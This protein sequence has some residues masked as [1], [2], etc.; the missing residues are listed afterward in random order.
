MEDNKEPEVLVVPVKRKYNRKETA[1]E[2]E[3]ETETNETSTGA[4][5]YLDEIKKLQGE[6]NLANNKVVELTKIVESMKGQYGQLEQALN[7][8]RIKNQA[9]KEFML[10]AAKHL[11]ISMTMAAK[12]GV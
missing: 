1:V 8:E 6:L 9:T 3:P 11:Y 7:T 12:S 10:D 2:A 4:L 5:A